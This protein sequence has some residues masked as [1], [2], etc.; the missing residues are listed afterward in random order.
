MCYV[1]Y[2]KATYTRGDT[3]VRGPQEAHG[4]SRRG[5]AAVVEV[6][7]AAGAMAGGSRTQNTSPRALST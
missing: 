2:N 6:E 4:G 3:R 1:V 7:E 5:G